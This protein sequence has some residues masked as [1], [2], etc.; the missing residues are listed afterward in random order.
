MSTKTGATDLYRWFFIP[1][2]FNKVE[3]LDIHEKLRSQCHTQ[4]EQ[5]QEALLTKVDWLRLRQNLQ[6]K[7]Q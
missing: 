5:E 7:K 3:T 1:Y 6:K 4:Q 2:F